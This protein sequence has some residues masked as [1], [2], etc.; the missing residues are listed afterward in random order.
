[1]TLKRLDKTK[2]TWDKNFYKHL[3]FRRNQ[4]KRRQKLQGSS[5]FG[6][7]GNKGSNSLSTSILQRAYKQHHH[8]QKSFSI[9]HSP[10]SQNKCWFRTS[11]IVISQTQSTQTAIQFSSIQLS[12]NTTKST[13]NISTQQQSTDNTG[14]RHEQKFHDNNKH[15]SKN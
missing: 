11:T 10:I 1:M 7:I 2:K 3:V 5:K 6:S 12:Y 8:F 9:R 14:G 13:L 15:F 4:I